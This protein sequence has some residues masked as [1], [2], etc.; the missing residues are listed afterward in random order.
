MLHPRTITWL[1]SLVL[2]L[3]Q[4][5]PAVSDDWPQWQGYHRTGHSAETDLQSTWPEGGPHRLWLYEDCG[6]G[7]SGPAVVG[8]RLYTMGSRDGTTHL[9][10]I[11]TRQGKQIW[12]TPVGPEFDENQGNGPRSTPT[13]A[14]DHVFGLTCTGTLICVRTSDG[15]EVWR[16]TMQDFGGSMPGYGFSESV[17]VEGNLVVCTPG[18]QRGSVVALETNTGKLHWQSS[19]ITDGTH[20]A[21]ML[22]V[23]H[24]GERQLIQLLPSQVVGLS[25]EDGRVLWKIARDGPIA[26][27]TTP[28]YRNG[29][30]YVSSAY[31]AGCLMFH[32]GAD[33]RVEEIYRNKILRNHHGGVVL[34]GNMLIGSDGNNSNRGFICQDFLEGKRVW[35]ERTGLGGGAVIY[36]DGRLYILGE[37]DAVVRL[38]EVSE[39]GWTLHGKFQMDPPSDHRKSGRV[40]THPVI[41][42]G[43]LYLRDQE[44]LFCYDVREH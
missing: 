6:T 17:L 36:A 23:N 12:A 25:P 11:D 4:P 20:Y 29:Y 2:L 13:V 1:C 5:T 19:A 18:G 27:A 22:P 34:A 39:E 16:R 3:G 21:S 37:H 8:D 38:V 14:G 42:D 41:A 28:I 9:L 33:N 26:V 40:W 31:G 15:K 10:A 43:K 44:Y 7:Y 32:V 24:H 30:V 35:H